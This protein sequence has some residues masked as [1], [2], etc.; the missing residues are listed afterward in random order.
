MPASMRHLETVIAPA[1]NA[2]AAAP[3]IPYCPDEPRAGTKQ[4][5][6]ALGPEKFAAWMRAETRVLFYRYQH[7]ETATSRC[8]PR[9]CV[10]MILPAS[11]AP[12]HAPCLR[13]SRSNVGRG[14]TFDVAMRFLTEDPWERLALRARGGAEH[15]PA[16][17]A[18]RLERGG[19]H[20]LS[21]NVVR[22]FVRAVGSWAGSTFSGVFR[23]VST[24][25][26][27]CGR[28]DAVREEG[29][30]CEAAI[31][32][33]GDLADAGAPEI[34]FEILCRARPRNSKRRARIS[35]PSRIWRAC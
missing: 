23:T 20:Q 2:E 25:S 13:Y 8:S 7:C 29:R 27:T 5:L 12:M 22:Y 9:A 6:D 30:L 28:M 4:R 10:R 3:V 11:P 16:D 32:Y 1:R 18:A 26:R 19:L 31:C 21:D 35:S 15:P 24:G 34:R 17:A 33:T 14:E